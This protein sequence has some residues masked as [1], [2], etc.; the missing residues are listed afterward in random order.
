MNEFFH[1]EPPLKKTS[2]QF[3]GELFLLTN[4]SSHRVKHICVLSSW[5]MNNY[6]II[7][8]TWTMQR[9]KTKSRIN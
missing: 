6:Y 1:K 2:T 5:F 9:T 3:P 8:I 7:F 4:K